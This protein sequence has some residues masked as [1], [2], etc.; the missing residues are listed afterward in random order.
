MR[1]KR[2]SEKYDFPEKELKHILKPVST[3]RYNLTTKEDTY[4]ELEIMESDI[5]LLNIIASVHHSHYK[6][7]DTVF[8][9]NGQMYIYEQ[10]FR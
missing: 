6:F 10:V 1:Y 9:V 4:T 7:G 3:K 5:R 2:V 8:E